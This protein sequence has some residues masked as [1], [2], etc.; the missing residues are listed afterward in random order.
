MRRIRSTKL[1]YSKFYGRKQ[2]ADD[3]LTKILDTSITNQEAT[4]AELLRI[5]PGL[6]KEDAMHWY[7]NDVAQ[8]TRLDWSLLKAAFL[9]TF[10][11]EKSMFKILTRLRSI[12]MKDRESVRSYA[13]RVKILLDKINPPPSTE[14]QAEY[15]TGGLPREM[16]KFVRQN[17]PN[18]ISDAIKLS[19]KFVDVE[20]SQEKELKKEERV[21]A[22]KSRKRRSKANSR[23]FRSDSEVS[24]SDSSEDSPSTSSE[25]S[26]ELTSESEN[27]DRGQKIKDRRKGQTGLRGR[28]KVRRVSKRL[29][30]N[31]Q[32]SWI[33]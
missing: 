29:S 14:I 15:F 11:K 7:H 2:D 20:Q 30:M 3:C 4:D 10:Q 19:Q 23:R 17:D 12:K 21:E 5:F 31:W 1:K 18:T 13:R 9:N 32:E 8:A 24:L 22:K 25:S 27:S 6:M 26:P 28:P 16:N 33:S